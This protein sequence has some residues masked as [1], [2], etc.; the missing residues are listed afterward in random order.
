MMS[1]AT[2]RIEKKIKSL[3]LDG[4]R[5]VVSVFLVMYFCS[6][7]SDAFML[8]QKHIRSKLFF[9]ILHSLNKN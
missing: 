3:K 6:W 8:K 5:F 2:G 1:S 4:S 7:Q 9:Q